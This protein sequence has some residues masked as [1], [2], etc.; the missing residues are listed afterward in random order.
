MNA[1]VGMLLILV[2][3][4]LVW[5]ELQYT[6]C[7]FCGMRGCAR[8]RHSGWLTKREIKRYREEDR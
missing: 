2:L 8:C 4:W 3:G 6:E 1:L 7:P 5:R